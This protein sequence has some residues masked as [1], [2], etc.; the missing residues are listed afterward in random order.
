ME[1]KEWT[2]RHRERLFP[3][4]G[5]AGVTK[6][7]EGGVQGEDSEEGRETPRGGHPRKPRSKALLP[8]CPRRQGNVCPQKALHKHYSHNPP[9][10]LFPNHFL[11]VTYMRVQ[12]D[13]SPLLVS[14][15]LILSR[16]IHCPP[17]PGAAILIKYLPLSA[18]W[19]PPIL[20]RSREPSSIS[21]QHEGP[22]L[23]WR[24]Q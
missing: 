4:V 15:F 7:D 9:P 5:G 6:P 21:P 18:S 19:N 20:G 14:P 17:K 2:A 3:E 8:S 11:P 24:A 22:F 12:L 10:H 16:G 13:H 1:A 23:C